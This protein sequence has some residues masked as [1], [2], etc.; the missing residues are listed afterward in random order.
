LVQLP[1]EIRS[2]LKAFELSQIY[3]FKTSQEINTLKSLML[4]SNKEYSLVFQY[5]KSAGALLTHQQE[6][7]QRF[8][9]TPTK[10]FH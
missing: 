5:R 8:S 2:L 10:L 6:C 3:N 9:K 4:I 1:H 7:Q